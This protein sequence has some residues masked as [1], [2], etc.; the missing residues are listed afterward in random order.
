MGGSA[1]L[2][3]GQTEALWLTVQKVETHPVNG[4]LFAVITFLEI[5]D[6]TAFAG[7]AFGLMAEQDRT[8]C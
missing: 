7:I 5:L 2:T 3:E 6:R 1:F 8:M 4:Y